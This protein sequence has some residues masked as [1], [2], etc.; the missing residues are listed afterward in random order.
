MDIQ[1]FFDS[2]AGCH[3]DK[4]STI[5]FVVFLDK[6]LMS[7]TFREQKIAAHSFTKVEYE[8]YRDVAV[9]LTWLASL[10]IEIDLPSSVTPFLV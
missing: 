9:E 4:K 8:V 10:L 5:E 6:K 3:I 7:W 1:T 2:K